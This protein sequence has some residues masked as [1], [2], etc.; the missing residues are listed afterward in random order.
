VIRKA[1]FAAQRADQAVERLVEAFA[2]LAKV[3]G[4]SSLGEAKLNEL[5]L[6]IRGIYRELKERFKP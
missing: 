6:T 2:D 1:V 5:A 4:H 3:R